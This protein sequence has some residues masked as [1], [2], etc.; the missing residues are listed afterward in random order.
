VLRGDAHGT[1]GGF[2]RS[3]IAR[4]EQHPRSFAL[5]APV[6]VRTPP[7]VALH[8]THVDEPATQLDVVRAEHGADARQPCLQPPVH[9][10]LSP[11]TV[12]L[13]RA[14]GQRHHE[15]AVCLGKGR[16]VEAALQDE[17]FEPGRELHDAS[18]P[19]RGIPGA[20]TGRRAV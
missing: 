6:P 11:C 7:V 20:N 5:G 13:E 19:H 14:R 17:R 3:G 12:G 4:A 9:L 8:E 10:V 16:D 15:V 1:H 2:E 18:V